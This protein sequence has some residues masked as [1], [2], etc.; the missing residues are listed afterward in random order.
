MKLDDLLK[1][2]ACLSVKGPTDRPVAGIAYDSRQ[3]RQDYVFVAIPGGHR[4]GME[5]ADDAVR[6]GAGVIV[7]VPGRFAPKDVTHV[8]VQSIRRALAE[9]ADAF[10]NHPSAR[11]CT[12]GITGTNGKTTTAFLV[13][14]MLA[15]EGRAPGLIGTVQYEVGARILPA[16]RTTPESADL[17]G[18][19]DQMLH[20]GCKSVAMEVSSHAL[21][22]DRVA[23]I[24]F[25]AA[26]FTNLTRDHLDYHET[27]GRY[28]E[29]KRRLFLSLGKGAKQATAIIN[30][31]DS[32][33]KT[34]I[35]YN[36]I[37][38]NIVTYGFGP[39]AVVR[40]EEVRLSEAG[41][42]FRV[43]SPWGESRVRL[44][45]LGR[46]NV[47]N[48]LAAYAVGRA[49]GL[50][51]RRVVES[52]A[53]RKGVPGRLEEIPTGRRWRVFVDYAH[54]DD[55]L[56]NAL[57][58]LR[59]VTPGRLIAVFGCGGNRD[60]TKR[61]LMGAVA[62][63]LADFSILTSDNPRREDPLAILEQIQAGF[64][65]HRNCNKVEDRRLAIRTALGM[66]REGDV[67]LIAGKGH[68]T[69]Q[70]F[71]NTIVPF[72]DRQVAGALLQE[73]PD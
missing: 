3:V 46:F 67:V 6:R 72:D 7:S 48:A 19:L 14:D 16:S 36:E 55:A 33:G 15:A 45:L 23:G 69:T 58:T 18:L 5:F 68:E 61:P 37:S 64:G 62:A 50:D 13:R 42:E 31:D 54:T 47:Y 9:L 8:Q 66:A 63:R 52:L 53:A 40:A 28:F 65:S 41:S 29:A 57:Q 44:G 56:E 38:A 21:D 32:W 59:S 24:D 60:Q 51:E 2:V 22:Q 20:A 49:L 10:H 39:E 26:V 17:Q 34:L 1:K 25:D 35:A 30:V 71:A 70:E 73:L 27:M 11:L 43:M 12:V 4:D